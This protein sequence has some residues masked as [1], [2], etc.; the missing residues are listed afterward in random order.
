M[1]IEEGDRVPL[2]DR[3]MHRWTPEERAKKLPAWYFYCPKCGGKL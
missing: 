3:T 1:M 2:C